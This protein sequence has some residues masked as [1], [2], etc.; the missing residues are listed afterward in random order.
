MLANYSNLKLK[1]RLPTKHLWK[2]DVDAFRGGWE[3][4]KYQIHLIIISRDSW[5]LSGDKMTCVD[6]LP[7]AKFEFKDSSIQP[8]CCLICC[9]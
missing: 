5:G 8:K 7:Q 1:T 4:H 2:L 3:R 6:L 9:L